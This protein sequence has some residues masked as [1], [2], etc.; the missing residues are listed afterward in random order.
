[1]VIGEPCRNAKTGD[2]R[3][4]LGA[5]AAPSLL[6]AAGQKRL[7]ADG[8]VGQD[9]GAGALRATDLVGGKAQEIDLER[10]DVDGNAPQRLHR[11]AEDV[12]AAR[13]HQTRRVG[14]RMD[15]SGLVV[16]KHKRKI[17]NAV[18]TVVRIERAFQSGKIDPAGPL[19]RDS[20]QRGSG[21]TSAGE[22]RRVFRRADIE[23]A[24]GG[25]A[26]AA[27]DPRRQRQRGRLRRAAGENHVLR[28]GAHGSG[29][30]FA[31]SFR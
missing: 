16:G 21:K 26:I 31:R 5:G 6:A 18:L 7:G 14:D 11:V 8:L 25:K 29:D 23:P 27:Q 28:L 22:D 19:H 30:R 3:H 1:M 17:G 24:D 2:R 15:N 13:L 12:A 20:G 9:E 4:V 10:A